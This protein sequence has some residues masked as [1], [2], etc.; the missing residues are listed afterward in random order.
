MACLVEFVPDELYI[1]FSDRPSKI[2]KRIAELEDHLQIVP[3]IL[4]RGDTNRIK[5]K[6]YKEKVFINIDREQ[7]KQESFLQ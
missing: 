1:L 6:R 5:D 3:S 7:I 2:T 4:Y